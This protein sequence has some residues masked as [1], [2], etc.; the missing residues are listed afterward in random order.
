MVAHFKTEYFTFKTFDYVKTVE[1]LSTSAGE[2]G[3]LL[4]LKI[5]DLANAKLSLLKVLF[6]RLFLR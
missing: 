5:L 2:K 1:P 4:I 3:G 6:G